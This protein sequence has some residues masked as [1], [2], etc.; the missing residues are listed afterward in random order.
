MNKTQAPLLL[1]VDDDADM[2]AF[3]RAGLEANG[4]RVLEA[5]T[6]ERAIELCKSSGVDL[7]LLDINLLGMSGIEVAKRLRAETNV[8]FIFV[9]GVS[10]SETVR[11]AIAQGALGYYLKPLDIQRLIPTVE[12]ALVR[13]KDMQRLAEAEE[14]LV[15]AWH[16]GHMF[17]V[18][19]GLV[20]ERFRLRQEE[21]VVFLQQR[22]LSERIHVDQLASDIVA[23]VTALSRGPV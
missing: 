16:S 18:A 22:A 21:A 2:R 10:D 1:L 12:T 8:H 23:A 19:V 20:M 3:M 9:S 11:M 13:S 17:N 6:G 5:E 7:A 4:F 15:R 14:H